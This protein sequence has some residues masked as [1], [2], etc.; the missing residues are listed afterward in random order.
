MGRYRTFYT[1]FE[2][3]V[4]HNQDYVNSSSHNLRLESSGHITTAVSLCRLPV[5]VNNDK[6][7]A[8]GNSISER[9]SLDE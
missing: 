8:I 7:G 9:A 6:V 2:S 3:I 4:Y 1:F 5:L